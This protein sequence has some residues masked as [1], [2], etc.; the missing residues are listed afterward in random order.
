MKR[1]RLACMHGRTTAAT[2]KCKGIADTNRCV[3]NN[4]WCVF[5]VRTFAS[6]VVYKIYFIPILDIK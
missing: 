2:K 1:D 5:Y 6:S 3:Y 4:T